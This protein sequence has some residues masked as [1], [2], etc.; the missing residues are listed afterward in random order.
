MHNERSWEEVQT[1]L[2][3]QS[4]ESGILARSKAYKPYFLRF[5]RGV[6]IEEGCRFSHPG[7]IVLDDD[8]RINQGALIYGSGGIRLGRHC[9][10]GP[11]TFIHSANHDISPSAEAFFERGYEYE[12]VEIGDNCLISANVSIL[13]GAR[14]GAG[15]FVSCGGV[16]PRGLYEQNSF[17]TGVPARPRP[18]PTPEWHEAP[19]IA[20]IAAPE[21]REAE[22]ARLLVTSLG[23]PQVR[24]FAPD[25]PIPDSVHATL[26]LDGS[27]AEDDQWSI[28]LP[29]RI[30]DGDARLTHPFSM[31]DTPLPSTGQHLVYPAIPENTAPETRAAI[32]SL[33][34]VLKRAEKGTANAPEE[35]LILLWAF[36]R[37]H[38]TSLEPFLDR[39]AA[40]HGLD[41]QPTTNSLIRKI[42][43]KAYGE[44]RLKRTLLTTLTAAGFPG[45]ASVAARICKKYFSSSHE[46]VFALCLRCRTLLRAVWKE[47]AQRL[48]KTPVPPVLGLYGLAA[49]MHG[50]TEIHQQI[51]SRLL[52]EDM[53]D[54]ETGL[55]RNRSNSASYCYSPVLSGFLALTA[56]QDIIADRLCSTTVRSRSW[57]V[58]EDADSDW[59]ISTEHGTGA[60]V[61]P[62][63]RQISS[64]LLTNWLDS[65]TVPDLEDGSYELNENNYSPNALIL[66]QCWL[67]LF[68]TMAAESGIT[69]ARILPWPQGYENALSITF[70]VD[71]NTSVEQ[72]R[73]LLDCQ[74]EHYNSACASWYFISEAEHSSGIPEFVRNNMQESG[75][76]A[77]GRR[78]ETQGCGVTFHSGL[79]SDYWEGTRSIEWLERDNALYGEILSSQIGIPRPTLIDHGNTCRVTDVWLL[80]IRFPLEGATSDNSLD[81]FDR[82]GP[83]FEELLRLGGHAIICTHPDLRHGLLASLAERLDMRALWRVP[84]EAAVE[85]CRRLLSYGAIS[86]AETK[87]G[88]FALVSRYTIA[89]VQV[90]LFAPGAKKSRRICI[91]MN[92]G[93][94][95]EVES[96]RQVEQNT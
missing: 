10:I 40:P 22:A 1:E 36:A 14:L 16:V 26:R 55:I 47:R 35:L 54:A 41:T 74:R 67:A 63:R 88:G 58:Y 92:S 42:L 15:C 6:R 69:L 28:S 81:Y 49:V 86:T 19:A 64:S 3:D 72:A 30:L 51:L 62:D 82:L 21:S 44:K 50:E 77:L 83:R 8:T 4:G 2:A 75:V 9:R 13:P 93:F 12:R 79:R 32:L 52:S 85:R 24:V 80:P 78:N 76:H 39:L 25:S 45:G 65:L 29:G 66:E 57:L 84:V 18:R 61:S 11:R 94:P 73:S 68:R 17:L 71:R 23:L 59:K 89:D 56:D 60:Y 27:E 31:A 90:E 43:D 70:D 20:V 96:C 46:I 33:R 48:L 95:R 37:Q 91:Q 53:Y 7:R 34:A 5:G 38:S 87:D